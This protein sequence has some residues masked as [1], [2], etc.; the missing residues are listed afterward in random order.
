LRNN[1]VSLVSDQRH[2]K[3]GVGADGD[4]YLPSFNVPKGI[5]PLLTL[6]QH[7]LLNGNCAMCLN[8]SSLA[9]TRAAVIFSTKLFFTAISS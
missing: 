6:Y 8:T 3:G 7:A 1:I 4:F 9:H 5:E 2:R